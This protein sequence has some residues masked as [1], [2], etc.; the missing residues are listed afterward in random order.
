MESGMD[1]LFSV[2]YRPIAEMV[3]EETN[4]R[5]VP[6]LNIQASF[7]KPAKVGETITLATSVSRWGTT[8]FDIDYRFTR[9]EDVLCTATQTRV[10][11][12]A[13]GTGAQETIK[14]APIPESCIAALSV[15]KQVHIKLIS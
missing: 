3:H 12:Y 4:Y 11:C 8:S 2:A 7:Q 1:R 14:P 5:G 6:L 10:W 13:D 9:G 15:D